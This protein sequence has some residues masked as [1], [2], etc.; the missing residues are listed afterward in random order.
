M[1]TSSMKEI[2]S[3]DEHFDQIDGITKLPAV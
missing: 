1:K 3:F 2:Y